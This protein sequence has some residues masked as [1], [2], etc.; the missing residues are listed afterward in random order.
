MWTCAKCNETVDDRFEVCWKCGTSREGVENPDFGNE[1]DPPAPRADA[2]AD[3]VR[4]APA[5]APEPELRRCVRCEDMGEY[6]G[7]GR[8]FLGRFYCTG[9]YEQVSS[10]KNL[11]SMFF[12]LLICA[13]ILFIT[14]GFLLYFLQGVLR[15]LL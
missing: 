8:L 6:P 14:L 10:G 13:W 9:C 2:E 1:P 7:G 4:T 15:I 5:P 3:E 11:R 12:L